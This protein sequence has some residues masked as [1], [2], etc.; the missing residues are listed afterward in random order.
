MLSSCCVLVGSLWLQ[1]S[2]SILSEPRTSGSA[3][4]RWLQLPPPDLPGTR[5]P[6]HIPQSSPELSLLGGPAA[7]L[8]FHCPVCSEFS[9][10]QE[11]W[12]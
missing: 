12:R 9:T 4:C 11:G 6:T 1:G 7:T 2:P 8:L 3:T 5:P 10:F